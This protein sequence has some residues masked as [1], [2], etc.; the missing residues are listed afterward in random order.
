MEN[1]KKQENDFD[2]LVRKIVEAQSTTE[3]C[4]QLKE[5]LKKRVRRITKNQNLISSFDRAVDTNSVEPLLSFIRHPRAKK[6]LAQQANQGAD[7][8]LLANNKDI[9]GVLSQLDK[10]IVRDVKASSIQPSDFRDVRNSK[11]VNEQNPWDL[12]DLEAQYGRPIG[13]LNLPIGSFPIYAV[14]DLKGWAKFMWVSGIFMDVWLPILAL[15]MVFFMWLKL[16]AQ[17][18]CR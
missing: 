14:K 13:F 4:E 6:L 9:E 17:G 1:I 10:E 15:L 2:R 12:M 18:D 5:R 7:R 11:E 3:T 8:L 16:R